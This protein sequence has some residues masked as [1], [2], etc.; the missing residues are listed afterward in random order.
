[1]GWFL[2]SL[3]TFSSGSLLWGEKKKQ[4]FLTQ[5]SWGGNQIQGFGPFYKKKIILKFPF[6]K[7]HH[8][9]KKK[10][11]QKKQ[12]IKVRKKVNKKKKPK[13]NFKTPNPPKPPTQRLL[14]RVQ[15][16]NLERGEG[17]ANYCFSFRIHPP[18]QPQKRLQGFSYYFNKTQKKGIFFFFAFN[19]FWDFL[20]AWFKTKRGIYLK[21]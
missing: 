6:L 5:I 1:M 17:L 10:P 18:P 9:L 3:I 12:K 15:R 14:V 2:I 20:K 11:S 7:T 16:C 13:F 8:P 4:P 21:T 19:F